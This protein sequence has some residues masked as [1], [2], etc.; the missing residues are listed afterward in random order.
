[1]TKFLVSLFLSARRSREKVGEDAKAGVLVSFLSL[2]TAS[3]WSR[4]ALFLL[5]EHL[6]V[7]NDA[8][9]R[10]ARPVLSDNSLRISG[11]A[12]SVGRRKGW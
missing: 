8:R 2:R 9:S 4:R 5:A 6:Q 10:A 3:D 11:V 7:E 12:I 1:M